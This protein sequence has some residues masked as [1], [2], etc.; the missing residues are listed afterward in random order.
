MYSRLDLMPNSPKVKQEYSIRTKSNCIATLQYKS[1][2]PNM[3]LKTIYRPSEE[4]VLQQ[5]HIGRIPHFGTWR[6][7]FCQKF[8]SVYEEILVFLLWIRRQHVPLKLLYICTRPHGVMPL[9]TDLFITTA[10]NNWNLSKYMA[11]TVIGLYHQH[12]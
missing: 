2:R 10:I 9:K 1:L 11:Y 6:R 12:I 4:E 5:S 7:V 8:I 3:F